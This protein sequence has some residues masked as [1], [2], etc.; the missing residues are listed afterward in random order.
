[1]A[2]FSSSTYYEMM[3]TIGMADNMVIGLGWLCQHIMISH[4]NSW[5]W[6]RWILSL[7]GQFDMLSKNVYENI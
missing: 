7:A 3:F 1:M 5:L 2:D 6:S 4:V